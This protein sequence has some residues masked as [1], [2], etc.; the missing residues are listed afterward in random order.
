MALKVEDR[1]TEEEVRANPES[2]TMVVERASD[3][4]PSIRSLTYLEVVEAVLKVLEEE[5]NNAKTDQGDRIL[6]GE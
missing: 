4:Y 3:G 1:Y 2:A 6:S 5:K